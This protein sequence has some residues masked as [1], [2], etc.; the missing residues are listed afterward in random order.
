MFSL[1]LS[2]VL[3]HAPSSI[4]GSKGAKSGNSSCGETC[5]KRRGCRGAA[6]ACYTLN[7][8]C[9][10]LTGQLASATGASAF[11]CWSSSSELIFDMA[12]P[13][14]LLLLLPCRWP[15]H[16]T[17]N[18]IEKYRVCEKVAAGPPRVAGELSQCPGSASQRR[19]GKMVKHNNIVP[20]AHFHK[21]WQR[22]VRTW[23]DQ[24]R[25]RWRVVRGTF[26][27]LQH[28]TKNRTHHLSH[29]RER[30]RA[31]RERERER[32]TA[33]ENTQTRRKRGITRK[34]PAPNPGHR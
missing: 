7:C 15:L 16:A 1:P 13:F 20:N 26:F 12:F 27:R 25:S 17:A 9:F 34:E 29:G 8:C 28:H 31:E 4:P 3:C 18:G 33:D 11:S 14:S 2:L 5:R 6:V 22:R 21:K 32:E 19:R 23:F 10:V 24:V 30:E